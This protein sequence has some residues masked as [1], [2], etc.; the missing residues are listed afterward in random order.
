M[1]FTKAGKEVEDYLKEKIQIISEVIKERIPDTIS[2][3]MS[4]GFGKGEGSISYEN[5]KIILIN[6]FDMYVVTKREHSEEEINDVAQESSRKIGKKGISSFVKFNKDR[7]IL[8]EFFYIDLKAIPFNQLKKLPPMV[9]FYDLR[10]SS[11]VVYGKDLLKYIPDFKAEKL[12]L[13]E[14]ARF[15]LNRMSHLVQHFYLSFFKGKVK[16]NDHQIFLLH[17]L[18]TYTYAG[19]SLLIPS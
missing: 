15:L 18:K 16:E 8:E 6:D 17:V 5:K 19:S 1:T 11:Q 9:K 3:I 7:P 13:A 10:N 2:V 4:G 14:G 12:P